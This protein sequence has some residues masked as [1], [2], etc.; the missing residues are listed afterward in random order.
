[1]WANAQRDGRP[2]K[3]MWRPFQSA[4]VSFLLPRC[5]VW[6]TPAAGVPCSN[7]A[8]IEGKTCRQSEFFTWQNSV[9]GRSPRIPAQETAIHRAKV[10][11]PPVSDVTAV[12]KAR[13]ET[14]WNLLGCSKLPKRSQPLVGRSLPYSRDML[15][16]SCCWKFF[17]KLSIHALVAK[18]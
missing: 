14:R 3:Y 17:F 6:L 11:W 8:N 7:A 4:A 13:H 10:G 2:A 18:T 16:R 1:M 9:G 15:R 5:K 12:P